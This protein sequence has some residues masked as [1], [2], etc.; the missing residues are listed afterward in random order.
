MI[1]PYV[2]L[3]SLISIASGYAARPLDK[4]NPEGLI[5]LEKYNET[6]DLLPSDLLAP[7]STRGEAPAVPVIVRA[8]SHEVIDSLCDAGYE[9]EYISPSVS[10]V[11]M[12]ID[13]IEN[14]AES[15]KVQSM[16]FGEKMRPMMNEAL[17]SG[18]VDVVQEGNIYLDIDPLKGAG[19][20]VGA[21]DIGFDPAHV[22]FYN[23][24]CSATRIK[25]YARFQGSGTPEVYTDNIQDAPTDNIDQ[26]HATHV[27]GIAAGGYNG[28]GVTHVKGASSSALPFYGVAPEADITMCS[29]T[30]YTSNILSGIRRMINYAG[31]QGKPIVINLS[32]GDTTGPH[33]GSEAFVVAL[34]EIAE[35][36]P[37][38]IASGNEADSNLHVG[39]FTV[40]PS[41][42]LRAVFKDAVNDVVEVW[43]ADD[44]HF[45]VS[46]ILVDRLTGEIIARRSSVH[47][48]WVTVGGDDPSEDNTLFTSYCTGSL[49]MY[50]YT[51]DTNSRYSVYFSDPSLSLI[52]N[53]IS[54]YCLGVEVSVAAPERIDIW[55]DPDSEFATI[56]PEGFSVPDPDGSVSSMACGKNTICVGAYNTREE[57]CNINNRTYRY[58]GNADYT[59]GKIAPYSAYG[60]L[61]DGRELPAVCAPG[62]G[63]ISSYSNQY[64]DKRL[65]SIEYNL[66]GTTEFN[67]T[68][69]YFGIMQGTSMA[70]AFTTGVV[71]LMLEACPDLTPLQIRDILTGTA[72]SQGESV[73]WG[74]GRINAFAAVNKVIDEY[75]T[76]NE[77]KIDGLDSQL[78]LCINRIG[79]KSFEVSCAGADK[80][81]VALY[82]LTGQL[83][84]T[85]S[86]PDNTVTLD[87]SSAV[88]GIYLLRANN[89]SRKIV[90]P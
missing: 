77:I 39:G 21:F 63:I 28:P 26:T 32:L 9:V 13:K 45:V 46:L 74:S 19:V 24:D 4:I 68:T 84:A 12:P 23:S 30:L 18:R 34:D 56:S 64:V 43:G 10:I 5:L 41:Q 7:S 49:K 16:S 80:I 67:G 2:I 8:R 65:S 59:I 54:N 66:C 86:A 81:E 37:V 3:L 79:E 88:P 17:R 40:T 11:N 52:G 53:Y 82:T 78:Y 75:A 33:D 27:M 55:A 29:G 48:D 1:K 83:I 89:L 35:E 36:Y 60:T 87:I 50:A 31:Q 58:G 14:L 72:D 70:C 71:A 22:N 47:D 25:Y 51:D 42:P 15:E 62:S 69:R 44:S 20:I 90:I 38:C 57:W 76:L 6:P 85:A 73:W 61:C